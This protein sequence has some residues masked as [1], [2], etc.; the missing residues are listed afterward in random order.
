MKTGLRDFLSGLKDLFFPPVCLICKTRLAAGRRDVMFCHSCMDA[1]EFVREP[2]CTC[3]GRGFRNSA[4]GS[5]LCSDCLAGS[6]HFSKARALFRYD[7][8]VAKL[9][10]SF[11]YGGHTTGL[12]TFGALKKRIAHLEELNGQDFIVPVPLHPKRLKQR[13]FNQALLLAKIFFPDQKDKIY[14]ALM[15]RRRW[16]EPQT[17]LKGKERRKN[18]KNAFVVKDRIRVE[19]KKILIVDDVFTTGTTVDECARTLKQAGAEDVQVLTL[20]RVDG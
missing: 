20:A 6:Y 2:F 12:A 17:S 18:L 14:P 19:G 9:L 8:S 1:I 13:G 5:H 16:T 3:C 7:D 15:E 4:G 11:K 10:H